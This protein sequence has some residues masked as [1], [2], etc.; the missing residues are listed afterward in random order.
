MINNIFGFC[1]TE[2]AI[3]RDLIAIKL[4]V[5]KKKHFRLKL[6]FLFDA[7]VTKNS[8]GDVFQKP[9]SS[10][11]LPQFKRETSLTTCAAIKDYVNGGEA[12]TS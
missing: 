2:P 4:I 9:V 5:V 8:G 10:N 7:H 6:N 3:V 1:A 11:V 12:I